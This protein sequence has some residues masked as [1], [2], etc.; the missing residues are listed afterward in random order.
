MLWRDHLYCK[1]RS[2]KFSE[3]ETRL[4]ELNKL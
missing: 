4:M 2:S 1:I 3:G